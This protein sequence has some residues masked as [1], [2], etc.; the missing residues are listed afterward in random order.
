MSPILDRTLHKKE[1]E[2]RPSHRS[3]LPAEAN[4]QVSVETHHVGHSLYHYTFLRQVL[5]TTHLPSPVGKKD[6]P[7]PLGRGCPPAL[8]SWAWS[9]QAHSRCGSSERHR[10]DPLGGK[11]MPGSCYNPLGSADRYSLGSPSSQVN[12]EGVSG[13]R[14]PSNRHF[15]TFCACGRETQ[16]CQPHGKGQSRW[17]GAGG[18]A[19]RPPTTGRLPE[20]RTTS[21]KTQGRQDSP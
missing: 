20:T 7:I 17:A 8:A 10:A 21:G 4:I 1:P 16:E 5:P 14:S 6:K 2:T 18:Q 9:F 3:C 13:R 12:R 11:G 15:L 19:A